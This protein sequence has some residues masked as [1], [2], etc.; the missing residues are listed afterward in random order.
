MIDKQQVGRKRI[1][2]GIPCYQGVPAETLEDYMRLAYYLGRFVPDYEFWLAIKSKSEQFRARNA[3]VDAALQC[4]AEYLLMLDDDHVIDWE[5]SVGPNNRYGFIEQLIAHMKADPK[6]GICGALYYQRG[7]D[8]LPVLMKEGKDG[9]YYW[10][11]EDEIKGELQEVAVQGGGCMLIDMNV[12]SRIGSPWFEP[13]FQYG[14]DLQICQ[15]VRE[16]GLK[17]ACDTSI[18]IG[19][20]LSKREIVTPENRTRIQTES[21][22]RGLQYQ[23]QFDPEVTAQNAY[24]LYRIDVEDY[25]KMSYRDIVTVSRCYDQYNLPRFSEYEDKDEYYRSLGKE[26]LCRQVWFHGLDHMIE[27]AK[28]FLTLVDTTVEGYGLDFGCGSAPIGFELA[29]RGHRVDFVDL[30]GTPAYE[31]TKWRALKHDIDAGWELGGPY[32]YVL[33]LDSI[34]HIEDWESVLL[35]VCSRIAPDGGLLTNYFL[36]RDFDNPEHVSMDHKAVQSFLIS[37]GLYPVN[38]LMY[39]KRDLAFMEAS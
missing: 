1:L 19:H 7:G 6:I 2:V 5:V 12:F 14:T 36:N 28:M 24:N 3:I 17:V 9:G 32:Q 21:G 31:F 29:K 8:C 35:D 15:K 23:P 37:Q 22:S 25:L 27:Q 38:K 16:A 11:R 20:V 39:L 33:M 30:D 13:E 10:M 4:D 18:V 34:E 26:Q